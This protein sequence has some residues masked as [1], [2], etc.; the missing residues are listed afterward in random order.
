[1][2]NE[3]MTLDDGPRIDGRRR[4]L[5]AGA[6][7]VAAASSAGC[8][9]RVRSLANRNASE[10]VSL[11]VKTVPA[12]VD[13]QAVHIARIVANHLGEVGVDASVTPMDEQEL[14]R[15]IL[16]NNEFDMYVAQHPGYDDPDFLRS[17]LHSRYIEET[18]WQNPF[19]YSDLDVDELLDAQRRASGYERHETLSELQEKIAQ[20]QP[21]TTI[22][23][24]DDVWGARTDR[25]VGWNW[26]GLANPLGYLALEPA[27][28][29]ARRLDVVVTDARLTKNLN[30]LASEFRNRGTF[31]ELLY[32]SLARRY[33]GDLKPWLAEDWEWTHDEGDDRPTARVD[34]RE[35]ATWHDGEPVT[36][37]DVAFTYR[38]LADTSLGREDGPVP[39]PMFR[40]RV[41]LVDGV[42]PLDDRTVEVTFVHSDP[43]VADRALTVPIL[44][45]RVWRE[46]SA[47]AEVAG[48]D[49]GD[50]ATEAVVWDNPEPVGS[51]PLR[52]VEKEAGEQVVFA[53]F[54][55]HFIHGDGDDERPPFEVG[56]QRLVLRVV[57]SDS[58]AVELLATEQA[59]AT[60]SA[61]APSTVPEIAR[62]SDLNLV[63]ETSRSF[64]HLGFNI[65]RPPLGNPRFRRNVARLLDKGAIASEVFDGHAIPAAS[66]LAVTDWEAPALSWRDED[67]VLPFF[68]SDGEL[69]AASARAAFRDAG[70]RY[71]G[72]TLLNR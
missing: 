46:K 29:D 10:Q 54:D 52:F 67:P 59:D 37:S 41:S 15:D 58:S 13:P 2:G 6:A 5:L 39:A 16:I 60:A 69:D 25:F 36:A 1:M 72:D 70:Y 61:V 49:L 7:S 21:F 33:G 40:G 42:E 20:Q 56:F 19:N 35:N 8:V 30:P 22:V 44:P 65:Q 17:L 48:I 64:Y 23:F 45:E 24:P 63:A 51:G 11:D 43:G 18:G 71:D 66:P 3:D 9:R 27:S 53:R 38:F 4:A 12:D 31:T 14:L 50:R 68:G 62:R 28:D 34:L 57:P 32:D 55:D 47:D 26:Y